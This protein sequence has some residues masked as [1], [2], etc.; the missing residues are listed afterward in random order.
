MNPTRALIQGLA[1]ALAATTLHAQWDPAN[2]D[3]LKSHDTDYRVMTW[4]VEDGLCSSNTKTDAFNNWNGIVRLIAAMQPDVVILQECGDNS[5]NGTGGG[6][7]SQSTLETVCELLVH[8]GSDPFEGGTVG[9]YIQLFTGT[10]YDL[11]YIY[12]S[13]SSDGFNRNVLLS[14]Y[15]FED[16][17]GGGNL[18][19]TFVV[20]ADEYAPGGTGGIRGQQYAEIDLPDEIYA[21]DVVIANSHLKSGGDS[22]DFN[23]RDDAARNIAYFIDYYYNGAGTGM[24][25]PNNRIPLPS[26]G[27][28]LDDN[29]PVIWGG[30]FN[31]RPGGFGPVER[32]TR[33]G[34]G[35]GTDGTDRD[36]AVKTHDA[37]NL[38]SGGQRPLS[39]FTQETYGERRLKYLQVAASKLVSDLESVRDGWAEGAAYRSAFT[40]V[41]TEADAAQKLTEILTGMGT[42]SE[43][44]LAG[45]RMQIAFSANSQEDEHSCFSD[46]THRD[47]WL[48]AEGVSNSYYGEYAGYDSD[49]DGIDDQTARAVDGYGFDDYVAEMGIEDLT[50]A[51]TVLEAAL[52]ET[53]TNYTAIDEQA[54]LG[55]PVD[56]LI[57]D[58]NRNADNPMYSTILSLNA[59]SSEIAALATALEITATVVD[60]DA[61]G[62]DTSNPD[63]EC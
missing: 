46:N 25:D 10:T 15:P 63:E 47:I 54:R 13:E 53:E 40:T 42:L 8:G 35:G 30:D 29:T 11:P 26:T 52:S 4:N 50:S 9:S 18:Y 14:R 58:V 55:M 48:N 31:Q 36:E 6:V 62:C 22:S 24:S 45:E 56:V 41:E 39:D 61:S 23:D 20:Q 16:I 43:G 5:G 17:N 1:V 12:V 33:A 34:V 21:G 19:S 38:A 27:S 49:L 28:V 37:A 3:W 7:D 32:M 60:D 59:Q 2:G 51:A 57:M 44:E